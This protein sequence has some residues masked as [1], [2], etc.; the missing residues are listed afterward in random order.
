MAGATAG[1]AN[2]F[3]A[4]AT[5]LTSP[6][7]A[8]TTGVQATWAANGTETASATQRGV[9]RISASRQAGA[10]SRIPPVASTDRAK[11]ALTPSPGSTSSSTSTATPSPRVPRERPLRPMPIS[12]TV[13]IAAARTT[14]GS[15]RATSTKPTIP[16][17]ARRWIQ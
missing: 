4:T 9:H 7:I 8:A 2:R 11:P 6:E 15:V 13:P 10:R 16:T 14:L 3:A 5:R 17:T 12:A 1:A